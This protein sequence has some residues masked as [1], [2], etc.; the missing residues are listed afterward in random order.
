MS[1]RS[2]LV[3]LVDVVGPVDVFT[4]AARFAGD[5]GTPP[6]VVRTASVDG[7]PV[8][9]AGGPRLVPDADLADVA[10]P[11]LLLV[12]GVPGC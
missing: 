9:A 8:L 2:V 1:T 6:Y 12:P 5:P 11:D 10:E 3:V 4:A 7:R